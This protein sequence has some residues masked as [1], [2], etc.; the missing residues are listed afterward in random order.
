MDKNIQQLCDNAIIYARAYLKTIDNSDFLI[1]ET[2]ILD[3]INFIGED[4]DYKFFSDFY[5][6]EKIET[7]EI[8]PK[9]L[10]KT[11]KNKFHSYYENGIISHIEQN[12]M[13]YTDQTIF[14]DDE[15]GAYILAD[16]LS[17]IARLNNLDK[18]S[19]EDITKAEEIKKVLK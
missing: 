12:K 6:K 1:D 17:F 14:I 19:M 8:S 18:V 4:I 16:F 9:L 15:I 10:L 3:S 2:V 7:T 5:H 11:L 13:Y